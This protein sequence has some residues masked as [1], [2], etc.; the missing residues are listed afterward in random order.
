MPHISVRVDPFRYADSGVPRGY[1]C[2]E[3]GA[4]GGKLWRLYQTFLN[5]QELRC[6][7]CAVKNA[8]AHGYTYPDPDF[9]TTDQ[10]GGM[11]PAV[12]TEEG[13][14]YWGYTSV[15][16]AGCDWWRRLPSKV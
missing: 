7:E 5:H 10:I 15:P 1:I 11:I 9:P 3:C 12:P 14:T 8:E 6:Q 2:G 16:Q 13:D 4:A